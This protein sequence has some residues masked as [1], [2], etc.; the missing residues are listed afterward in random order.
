MFRIFECSCANEILAWTIANISNNPSFVRPK[1]QL[2]E[3]FLF[4]PQTCLT[5][6]S[7]KLKLFHKLF[8]LLDE[9]SAML[10]RSKATLFL[11]SMWCPKWGREL[12]LEWTSFNAFLP[13]KRRCSGQWGSPDRMKNENNNSFLKASTRVCLPYLCLCQHRQHSSTCKQILNLP[14][15]MYAHIARTVV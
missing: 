11:Q 14:T 5:R 2:S 3:L 9:K 8:Q 7:A 1:Q 15:I 4:P 13:E 10:I 6:R 12:L